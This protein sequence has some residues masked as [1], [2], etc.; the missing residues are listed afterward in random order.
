AAS[1]TAATRSVLLG[2][3]S[4]PVSIVYACPGAGVPACGASPACGDGSAFGGFP[5]GGCWT[6]PHPSPP[7]QAGEGARAVA[8]LSLP[9]PLAGE[10]WG[11]GNQPA[12]AHPR[13]STAMRNGSRLA[14]G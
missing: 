1:A 7:P 3:W 9:P 14:P 11:G 4:D 6:H 5:M 2:G 12:T 13:A 10:G 8:R